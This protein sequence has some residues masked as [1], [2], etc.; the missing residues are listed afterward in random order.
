M[1]VRVQRFQVCYDNRGYNT[2]QSLVNRSDDMLTDVQLQSSVAVP[3]ELMCSVGLGAVFDI[4][5]SDTDFC[6]QIRDHKNHPRT[7]TR[8]PQQLQTTVLCFHTLMVD[9]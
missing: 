6:G 9:S 2:D 4:A 3:P 8:V 7:S 1:F 5:D